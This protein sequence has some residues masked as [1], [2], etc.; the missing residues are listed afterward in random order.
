MQRKQQLQFNVH[1]DPEKGISGSKTP[2]PAIASETQHWLPSPRFPNFLPEQISKACSC[3]SFDVTAFGNFLGLL[4][5]K[6]VR[7]SKQLCNQGAVTTWQHLPP[8]P[9]DTI[10]GFSFP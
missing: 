4:S 8:T 7:D 9:R 3:S 1:R 2:N 5:G 6:S 10:R